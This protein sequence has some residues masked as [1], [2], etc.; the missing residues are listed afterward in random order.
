MATPIKVG[1][2]DAVKAAREAN[3]GRDVLLEKSDGSR[4]L[5]YARGESRRVSNY[6]PPIYRQKK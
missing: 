2:I 5:F 1:D 4:W 3:K 6:R